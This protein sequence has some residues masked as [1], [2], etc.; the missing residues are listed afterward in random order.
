MAQALFVT[1]LA[2]LFV[3]LLLIRFVSTELYVMGLLTNLVLMA[4]FLGMGVGSWTCRE[5]ASAR[6]AQGW[7]LVLLTLFALPPT[8][9]VLNEV[10]EIGFLMDLKLGVLAQH[11]EEIPYVLGSL[12]LLY[13]LL[14]LV[15][16]IFVPFGRVVGR[17]FQDS[18]HTVR[19]YSA[20]VLGSLAGVWLFAGLGLA[21]QPPVVWIIVAVLLMLWLARCLGEGLP[22]NLVLGLL[23]TG[24]MAA[25]QRDASLLEL[26]WSPY[27]R[28]A[29]VR[30]SLDP[31]SWAGIGD[32][33][34]T[35]NYRGTYQGMVDLRPGRVASDPKRYPP[36]LAGVSQY[37]LPALIHPGPKT[38]LVVGAGS[39]NDV[40]GL[41]RNGV[42]H[43]TAVDIDPD[44]VRLGRRYHPEKPYSDPRVRVVIDDAR[45]FLGSTHEKFDLVVFGLLDSSQGTAG[46]G[47][48]LDSY[49]YTLQSLQQAR[50]VLKPGGVLALS[51]EP[52]F[53]EHV[54]ERLMIML[55]TVFDSQVFY[56]R[57]P[58]SGYGW[59]G[60]LFVA[61]DS[62]EPVVA[63]IK[64]K[65]RLARQM[66]D[67]GRE[68]QIKPGTVHELATDDWPYLYLKD[69][70]IPH[71]YWTL[72]GM[73]VLALVM[74]GWRRS[75]NLLT[76]WRGT[77]TH[78][79]LLGAAFLLLE[80][81]NISKTCVLF[82]STWWVNAVVIT[83]V[84]FLILAANLLAERFPRMPLTPVYAALWGSCAALY[85]LDLNR[86]AG[87]PYAV[88]AVT[89]GVLVCFPM[90][91]SGIVFIRSFA[92][93]SDKDHA[94]GSNLVGAMVGGAMQFLT[95]LLGFKAMMVVVGLLYLAA[96]PF[97]PR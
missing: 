56:V 2:S 47:R 18:P 33:I 58:L 22:V 41:L 89:V 49:V 51:F 45:S 32:Y 14:L 1:G 62:L 21:S 20:N 66:A 12:G 9:K 39:G 53:G 90:L 30:P 82:G 77:H 3:E 7:L 76:T 46:S 73:P 79:A 54:M 11:P 88:K 74:L 93:V 63:N 8:R 68:Y 70:R 44:I 61:S 23:L 6:R 36:E 91:F 25:G 37:D 28:V 92:A 96:W 10:N 34:V 27:Q 78:F 38:A 15:A 35:I 42:E 71:L 16:A 81:H 94:L 67:W 31:T 24:V 65:P 17:L 48:R 85:F 84:M 75:Y 97:R 43:V 60:V 72:L 50:A 13:L 57:I 55:N 4:C 69:R 26:V 95:F 52:G 64:S 19:A 87:L 86:L 5:P 40:A 80:T 29:L 83:G 59:G